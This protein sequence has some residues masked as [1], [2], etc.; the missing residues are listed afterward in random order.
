MTK[1]IF[2]NSDINISPSKYVYNILKNNNFEV[3]YI[4][5]CINFSFYKFKKR[6]KIRP[7][8][9][10]LRS[11]HEIYNPNMAIKVFKIINSS[12]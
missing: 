2:N 12:L 7:R 9:I 6:Q 8:I 4:P 11:F 3:K 5:N 10:W 1:F